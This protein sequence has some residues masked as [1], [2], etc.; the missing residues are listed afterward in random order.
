MKKAIYLFSLI[1][2]GFSSLNA[3][4]TDPN[5]P[6]VSGNSDAKNRMVG[7]AIDKFKTSDFMVQFSNFKNQMETD[8]RDFIARQNAY[9]IKDVRRVQIAYDKTAA[10]FNFIMLE[11]KQDFMDK[12]KVKMI[13]KFPDMYANGLKGKIDNLEDFYKANFQQTLADVTEKDGS[14]LL[15]LLVDLIKMAGEMSQHFKTLR[16]EKEYMNDQYIQTHLVAPNKLPSWGELSAATTIRT[17]VKTHESREGNMNN[18][19]NNGNM[20]NGGNNNGNMNNG[21]GDNNGG[22]NNGGGDNNA[23]N[24]NN[25]GGRSNDNMQTP[26]K[27][28]DTSKPDNPEAPVDNAPTEFGVEGQSTLK[29]KESP[30]DMKKKPVLTRPNTE[31]VKKT[32]KQND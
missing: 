3:Q 24:N 2:I 14:A 18:G 31:G 27:A 20:N 12:D 28:G 9:S 16:F 5:A 4:Q 29:K 11:I 17:D 19:G 6:V 21:G 26:T 23:N 7:N 25:K 10:K 13:N 15:L 8:A 30:S 22:N 1:T 32:V